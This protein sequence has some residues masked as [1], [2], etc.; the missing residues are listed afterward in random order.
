MTR[1]T[2]HHY[3]GVSIIM[4]NNLQPQFG[5]LKLCIQTAEKSNYFVV[6]HFHQASPNTYEATNTAALNDRGCPILFLSSIFRCMLSKAIISPVSIVHE[7]DSTCSLQ[8]RQ[9]RTLIEREQLE[10]NRLSIVHDYKN[11]TMF[12]LNIYCLTNSL[13]T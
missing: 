10:V 6:Q 7:C 8:I 12:L 4:F 5:H 1:Y 2:T 3:K 11:N 9:K 13:L